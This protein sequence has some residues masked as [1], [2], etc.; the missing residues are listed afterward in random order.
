MVRLSKKAEYGLIAIRHIATKVHGELVTAKEIADAYKIPFDLLAKVL[1]TLTK[2][3]L[4]VSVQGVHGGYALAQKPDAISVARI[5]N[6][7]EGT[8]PVIAQCMSG[9]PGSCGVFTLCTIKSPLA[10]VQA[11]IEEAFSTMTLAE[12]V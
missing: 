9:D 4:I 11:N 3:G 7:I 1:Q 6:A 10:K 5:I 2:A 12:I 8:A